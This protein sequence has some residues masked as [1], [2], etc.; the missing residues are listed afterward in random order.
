MGDPPQSSSCTHCGGLGY[1]VVDI[2]GDEL[3][4][5]LDKCNDIKE[6]VD[7]IK[8]MLD[9]PTIGIQKISSNLDDIMVKLDV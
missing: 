8:A 1:N 6:K 5:I 2:I 4:D 3:N 9:S 7:E